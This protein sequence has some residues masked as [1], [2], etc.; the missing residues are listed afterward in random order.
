MTKSEMV[1]LNPFG[2]THQWVCKCH[3]N[4]WKSTTH[5]LNK[6]IREWM[7]GQT[8]RNLINEFVSI[9]IVNHR[10]LYILP[11]KLT[12]S[13]NNKLYETQKSVLFCVDNSVNNAIVS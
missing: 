3:Q 12:I 7:N 4:Y 11:H 6:S 5:K 2:T 8:D 13:L 10:V 9:D 1:R